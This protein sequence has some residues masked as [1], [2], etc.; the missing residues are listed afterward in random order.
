MPAI[1]EFYINGRRLKRF[2]ESMREIKKLESFKI[3]YASPRKLSSWFTQLQTLKEII[4]FDSDFDNM[5]SLVEMPRM[6]TFVWNK[7]GGPIPKF[8]GKLTGLKTLDFSFFD[9]GLPAFLR[10]LSELE[11][12]SLTASFGRDGLKKLPP[13]IG[14]YRKLKRLWISDT[15]ME[16]LPDSLANLTSDYHVVPAHL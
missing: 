12:L 13:W 1:R 8:T 3:F 14:D 15:E 2:P 5:D 9:G 7:N 6:E 16:D 11:R 4:F 10:N